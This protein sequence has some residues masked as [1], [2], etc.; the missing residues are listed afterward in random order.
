M[1]SRIKGLVSTP[2]SEAEIDDIILTASSSSGASTSDTPD[3]AAIKGYAARRH[4]GRGKSAS[5][6]YGREDDSSDGNSSLL[7][8]PD[9]IM[10][11]LATPQGRAG[12]MGHVPVGH[13]LSASMATPAVTVFSVPS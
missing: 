13:S 1:H 6:G 2:L 4:T 12:L 3:T 8:L 5:R 11:E 9:E 7:S 10:M